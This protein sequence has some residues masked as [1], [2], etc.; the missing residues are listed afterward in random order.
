[1]HLLRTFMNEKKILTRLSNLQIMLKLEMRSDD[2]KILLHSTVNPNNQLASSGNMQPTSHPS[3][4]GFFTSRPKPIFKKEM[5]LTLVRRTD[6]TCK[7]HACMQP[8]KL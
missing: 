3:K 5:I 8:N 4:V 6:K 7:M 1:M 2:V